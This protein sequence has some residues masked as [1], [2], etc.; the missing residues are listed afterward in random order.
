MPTPNSIG[1]LR[2]FPT[3]DTT[4]LAHDLNRQLDLL[5]QYLNTRFGFSGPVTMHN[6]VDFRG[7]PAMNVGTSTT[8]SNAATVEQLAALRRQVE[9]LALTLATNQ[10]GG[11]GSAQAFVTLVDAP[12][13]GYPGQAGKGVAVNGAENALE[14]VVLYTDEM[15]QDAVAL[16]L[17]MG[18]H[19]G[20]TVTYDDGADT[21]SLTVLSTTEA[22]WL[23][24]T[25][26]AM[27]DPGSG[28]FRTN[29]VSFAASTQL[30]IHQVSQTNTDMSN[31]LKTIRTDDLIALQDKGNAANWCRYR[32][33][34]TPVDNGTWWRM[35]VA[36]VEGGG[37][38]PTNNT[39][40][41]V[42]FSEVGG[43][44]GG[45]GGAGAPLDAEYVTS[46]ASAGLSAER[47]LVDTATVTWDRTVAGQIAATATGGGGVT[48]R[49][50]SRKRIY[51]HMGA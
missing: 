31:T 15:A 44:A 35:D 29:Q 40:V 50:T 43:G 48:V 39:P 11:G 27:A 45:G 16:A 20:I 5:V 32:V 23:F 13:G 33:T 47:V 10:P 28:R 46:V 9:A 41:I 22:E 4:A 17:Q 14:Y 24:S 12:P 49:D 19:T 3:K 21:L 37:T 30:A 38:I 18:T 2:V 36:F 25:N 7:N 42:R 1:P 6:S 51:M 34:A 26:V 8:A